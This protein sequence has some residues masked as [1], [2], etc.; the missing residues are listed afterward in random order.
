[1]FPKLGYLYIWEVSV[2]MLPFAI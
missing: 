1:M 2:E